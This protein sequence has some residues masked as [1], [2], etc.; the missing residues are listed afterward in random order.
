MVRAEY[1]RIHSKY[2]SPAFCNEY[3]LHHKIHMDGYVYCRVKKGMY[4]LKQ[5]AILAYKLLVKR[6]SQDGYQPIPLTNGL[7][8]HCTRKTVF[9][10]CVD[11]FEKKLSANIIIQHHH[12]RSM[13]R[14]VGLNQLMDKKYSMHKNIKL[15]TNYW[16]KKVNDVCNQ[17]LGHF[18]TMVVQ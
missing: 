2:F 16:M 9:A 6:L 4:G 14:S 11:D 7:F 1:L 5:A 18:Y 12:D 15:P 17:W 10:L 8:R 3:N 13:I